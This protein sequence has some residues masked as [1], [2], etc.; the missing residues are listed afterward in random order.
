[1]VELAAIRSELF[2]RDSF[3]TAW[4]NGD[5]AYY[6][7]EAT[8]GKRLDPAFT[9]DSPEGVCRTKFQLLQALKKVYGKGHAQ[10]ITSW[11]IKIRYARMSQVLITYVQSQQTNRQSAL[12][13][14]SRVSIALLEIG[15]KSKWLHVNETWMPRDYSV[16]K[17]YLRHTEYNKS[18]IQK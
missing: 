14:N 3:L 4:Y 17:Y 10:K 18:K 8:L 15:K 9:I 11:D 6:D 5:V 7:L 16:D 1:M 13:C 2:Y 12:R